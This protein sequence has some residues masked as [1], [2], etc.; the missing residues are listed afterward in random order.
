MEKVPKFQAKL[1][2]SLFTSQVDQDAFLEALHTT[3]PDSEA[4]ILL[5]KN[6]LTSN[7]DTFPSLDWQN[8]FILRLKPDQR[9]GTTKSHEEGCIYCLDFSSVFAASVLN[10]INDPIDSIL[11][12]CA[13]PGGK[14]IFAW[15]LLSPNFIICNE[16]IGKR[17][18][19]LISNLKRCKIEPAFVSGLDVGTLSKRYSSLFDLVLVDAPC[20]GQ[21]LLVKGKPSPGAFHPSTINLNSNRQKRIIANASQCVAPGKY[22]VYMT[23]TFSKEENE[24]VLKW[25][26]KKF[27]NFVN[28][29]V[30]QLSEYQS[31]LSDLHCYRLYPQSKL[32]AGAFTALF[33]NASAGEKNSYDLSMEKFLWKA[34]GSNRI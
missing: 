16:V 24:D 20:S 7:F 10:C 25:F 31:T 6:E 18:A 2:K 1:A 15:K 17:I 30:D 26:V 3:Q 33:Q 21:S 19:A 34:D 14:A 4:L 32:G 12:V 28:I 9:P 23:C 27:P 5:T 29:K 13:A 8:E 22:L 11:D